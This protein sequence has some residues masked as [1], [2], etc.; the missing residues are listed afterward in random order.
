[1]RAEYGTSHGSR[2]SRIAAYI[3]TYGDG[4]PLILLGGSQVLL[5][6]TYSPGLEYVVIGLG[7]W[8]LVWIGVGFATGRVTWDGW[9]ADVR[10]EAVFQLVS[11]LLSAVVA[12]VAIYQ[13]VL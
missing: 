9:I 12:A 13:L 3:T 6:F 5:S 7:G 2:V 1:M 10:I 11:I 8:I 4:I